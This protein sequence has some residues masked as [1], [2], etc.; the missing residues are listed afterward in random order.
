MSGTD[1]KTKTHEN[2]FFENG[3]YGN[4][5]SARNDGL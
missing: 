1:V 2:K 5:H 4:I 3:C